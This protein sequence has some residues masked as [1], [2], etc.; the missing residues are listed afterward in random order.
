MRLSTLSMVQAAEF[1]NQR[2]IRD[3]LLAALA[4]WANNTP[5]KEDQ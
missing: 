1:I 2:V 3:D 5:N 4:D